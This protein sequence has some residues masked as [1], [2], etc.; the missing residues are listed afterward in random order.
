[1]CDFLPRDALLCPTA[2]ECALKG[3]VFTSELLCTLNNFLYGRLLIILLLAAGLY[4]T[5]RC[6]FVQLR[7]FPEALRATAEKPPEGGAVS[8]FG[9]LMVSTASRVGTGNIVGVSTAICM[10]GSGA[11]FWMWAISLIGG[12]TGFV[13]AVLAQIYKRRDGHGGFFGGPACY[14]EAVCR[15]RA[16]AVLFCLCL[17]LTYGLGFNMLSSYNLQSAFSCYG[18]YRADWAPALIGAVLALVCLACLLGGETL[19]VS[20]SEALVPAMALAYLCMA[21][22]VI[23]RH[24]SLLPSVLSEIFRCAF[25]ARAIFSG[26]AGSC[27]MYGVRRGLFSNEAGIGSAPNAA[28]SAHVSHPVKQGLVQTLSVFIDSALCTAT[29]LMCLCSGASAS[30]ELGGMPYVQAA[31]RCSF[32]AAGPVFITAAMVLFAFTSLLGNF[33]YIDNCLTYIL[34][35]RPPRLLAEA[36]R[37][38]AC[39][40]SFT[41]CLMPM[42]LVW[43][44]TDLLMCAMCLL[45][46]PALL[47]LGKR[48]RHCLDDY[49]RQRRAGK[50]PVFGYWEMDRKKTQARQ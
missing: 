12:A 16:P 11:V 27:V 38:A 35:R 18:F 39:V 17:I 44:I 15:C 32:G 10:G 5:L 45:N 31:A 19:I 7:M 14:I 24:L 8:S 22:T 20:I 36:M 48:V 4:F 46:L 21:L 40:L 49:R 2:F 13:E 42:E 37:L 50:D 23:L 34:R 47:V 3:A 41:G 25:D 33:F 30:P 26:F 6:G 29:A 28:A 1:M 43:N 9:A